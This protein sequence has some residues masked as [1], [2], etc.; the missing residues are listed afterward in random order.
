[1]L[2]PYVYRPRSS[3]VYLVLVVLI[4]T[5]TAISFATAGR[6]ADAINATLVFIALSIFI[7]VFLVGPKIVYSVQTLVIHNPFTRVTIGW[8]SVEEFEARFS[9]TVVTQIK[10]V[11]AWAAPAPTKFQTRR[12]RDAELNRVGSQHRTGHAQESDSN[13]ALELALRYQESATRHNELIELHEV[14][15]N[16]Q[17]LAGVVLGAAL[18]LIT[19]IH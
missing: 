18:L 19:L 7:W 12:I 8:A 5:A 13:A 16:T 10:K 9:F 3:W 11:S 6:T 15:V 14:K 17:A 4:G 1:M 2:K